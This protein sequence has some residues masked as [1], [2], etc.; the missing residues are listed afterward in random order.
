M[1]VRGCGGYGRGNGARTSED[2][3]GLSLL[4]GNLVSMPEPRS[5]LSLA[6]GRSKRARMIRIAAVVLVVVGG[7]LLW[8]PV[9]LGNG[10]LNVQIGA[11]EGA[12]AWGNGPVAF[13]LPLRN[14]SGALA[15]VD[16]VELVG[17]TRF[18]GP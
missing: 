15:V 10:P 8:G 7:F 5:V 6:R 18:P 17:G 2:Y 3:G 9:G 11:V 13:A 14:S 12:T 1:S 16:G 4:R